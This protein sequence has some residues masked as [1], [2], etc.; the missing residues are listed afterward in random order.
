MDRCPN[1]LFCGGE[2]NKHSGVCYR[3][4]NSLYGYFRKEINIGGHG[5]R[6]TI[7]E[8]GFEHHYY[9]IKL[10]KVERDNL[11]ELVKSREFETG[12]LEISEKVDECPICRLEKNIFVKHPTCGVHEICRECFKIT[13]LNEHIR[14]EEPEK[15]EG[16]NI[17]C[18]W[19]DENG[20]FGANAPD[21]L[22]HPPENHRYNYW[23]EEPKPE[24]PEHIKQ[25]YPSMARYFQQEYRLT[26]E[27]DDK[28][29]EAENLR[30]CPVCREVNLKI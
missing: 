4:D 11:Y 23:V 2:E 8:D 13:F 16:Y 15:P 14:L 7:Y 9:D 12:I 3:C 6:P 21:V 24:W 25:I 19:E 18:Q 17:F 10:S 29:N 5:V 22:E 27:Y 1:Y 28:I 20:I 26:G 30:A